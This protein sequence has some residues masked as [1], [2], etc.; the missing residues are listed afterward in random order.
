MCIRDR[1]STSSLHFAALCTSSRTAGTGLSREQA[2]PGTG[3]SH[4][5]KSTRKIGRSNRLN[6]V[7]LVSTFVVYE[8]GTIRPGPTQQWRLA[9]GRTGRRHLGGRVAGRGKLTSPSAE[10]VCLRERT[11]GPEG[12]WFEPRSREPFGYGDGHPCGVHFILGT[13]PPSARHFSPASAPIHRRSES[14]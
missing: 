13:Q 8:P 7:G 1:H 10:R 9:L 5:H 2:E 3:G 14:R 4:T 6:T 11:N 12:P